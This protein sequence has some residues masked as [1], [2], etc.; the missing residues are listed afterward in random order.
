M[1]PRPS[2]PAS[3]FGTSS[4][5][6]RS[7]HSFATSMSGARRGRSPSSLL[8]SPQS[9]GAV[10]SADPGREAL[11]HTMAG[12]QVGGIEECDAAFDGGADERDH[13]LL[14][15]WETVALA[16]PHAAEPQRRHFQT[17]L[18]QCALLHAVSLGLTITLIAWR[19]LS[20]SYLTVPTGAGSSRASDVDSSR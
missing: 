12:A 19:S 2:A 13:R 7:C 11:A 18:S 6:C 16:H 3:R 1:T 4:R 15:R 9:S 14:V 17:P 8:T 10:A 5:A 20:G